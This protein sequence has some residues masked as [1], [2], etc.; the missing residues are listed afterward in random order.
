MRSEDE[1]IS[2]YIDRQHL[3]LYVH[4][5]I[6]LQVLVQFALEVASPTAHMTATFCRNVH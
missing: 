3:A 5:F 4:V 2:I 1:N 6:F